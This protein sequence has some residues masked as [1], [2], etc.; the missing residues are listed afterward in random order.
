MIRRFRDSLFSFFLPSNFKRFS[1][2][3][4]LPSMNCIKMITE[5]PEV[6]DAYDV[7]LHL[8][9]FFL[10]DEIVFTADSPRH[11][12]QILNLFLF[13]QSRTG[14]GERGAHAFLSSSPFFFNAKSKCYPARSSSHGSSIGYFSTSHWQPGRFRKTEARRGN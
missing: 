12:I 6:R 4:L 14:P 2:Q 13:L 5:G 7:S 1:I 9:F 3:I 11:L 8:F 10:F